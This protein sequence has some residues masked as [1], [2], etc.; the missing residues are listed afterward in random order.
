MAEPA[1]ESASRQAASQSES[2]GPVSGSSQGA[3]TRAFPAGSG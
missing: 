1:R 2:A 3:T